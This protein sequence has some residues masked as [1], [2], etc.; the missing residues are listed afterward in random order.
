M[1]FN[2]KYHEKSIEFSIIDI[3]YEDAQLLTKLMKLLNFFEIKKQ[4]FKVIINNASNN[5]I[6][7]NEL[8]K[9]I[10]RRDFR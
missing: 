4:L 1:S 10:N 8:K 9:A 7:K 6:L 2:F 5:N 3:V